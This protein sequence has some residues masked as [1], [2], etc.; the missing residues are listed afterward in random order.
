MPLVAG[1]DGEW[2]SD[3]LRGL[4]W[5]ELSWQMD[6]EE[7]NAS[8]DISVAL[9]KRNE[10]AMKIGHLEIVKTMQAL[11]N[12]DPTTGV[13][14]YEPVRDK[15]IELYGS[16]V[17]NPECLYVFRFYMGQELMGVFITKGWRT[18]RP[19]S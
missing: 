15:L 8:L 11:L 4:E 9:N 6:V 16:N 2:H 18:S 5:E 14:K 19:S 1:R 17:D 7:P 13:V 10:A 12:P 3:I